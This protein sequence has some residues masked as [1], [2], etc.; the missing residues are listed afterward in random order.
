MSG[1][2]LNLPVKVAPFDHQKKAFEFVLWLYGMIDGTVRSTGAALLMQMGTGK[3]FV[4]V[5]VAGWMFLHGKIKRL[6]VVC[7]LSITGVWKDEFSKYADFPFSLTVLSGTLPK[8]KKQLAELPEDGL[9][10]VV[11]NYES[12]WRMEKELLAYRADMI[13]CDEG[14]KLKEGRTAQSKGMHKLGDKAKYRMLL[15]GTVIT[16]R[17]IDV[18][19]QYRFVAPQVFGSSFFAFRNRYFFMSGYGG[20]TP[21]FRKSMT[22]EFLKRMH[23]IAFRVRKDE[24]LDLP[25]ITEEI[26]MVDLEPEAAKLYTQIEEESYAEM[27]DSEVTAAN[28]LTRILRLSQI[29]GGFLKDDDGNVNQVSTAKL[30]ALS[31]IIDSAMEEDEKLVIMGRFVGMV[32]TSML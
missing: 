15:T 23:S 13:V 16:N 17:E 24:C 21:Y 7:P 3:S 20:H 29:T 25:E 18:F 2:D 9:Q 11:V 19:S 5:A 22:D 12:A 28:V 6:L 4:S 8:K 31:D 1:S 26:R 14:H 30:E 10:V 27:Q 32:I